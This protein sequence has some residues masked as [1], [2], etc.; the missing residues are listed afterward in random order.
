MLSQKI[1]EDTYT[2]M[3]SGI[4]NY[5]NKKWELIKAELLKCILLCSNCH[6]IKH[7]N[8]DENFIKEAI[9]YSGRQLE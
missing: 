6:R 7:S 4:A 9:K 8:R 2:A 1:F 3:L 5:K